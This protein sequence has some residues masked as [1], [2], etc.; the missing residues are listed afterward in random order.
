[1]LNVKVH[2]C[3]GTVD[4]YLQGRDLYDLLWYLSDPTWPSPN[5]MML[6]HAL[7][8]TGWQGGNLNETNWKQAVLF[9]L[10]TVNWGEAVND[11]RPFLEPSIDPGLLTLDN[12]NHLLEI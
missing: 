11:V 2:T 4:S 6:N 9:K 12:L 1:M 5:L 10:Q 7:Q 8:Q 3:S